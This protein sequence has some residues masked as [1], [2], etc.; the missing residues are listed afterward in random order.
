MKSYLA[1]FSLLLL[2]LGLV[3]CSGQGVTPSGLMPGGSQIAKL[4]LD[5][6]GGIASTTVTMGDAPPSLSGKQL[7]HLDLGIREIDVTDTQGRNKVVAQYDRPLMIDVLQ[8]QGGAGKDL[9]EAAIN[10]QTY[11]AIRFVVDVRVSHAIYA[12]SSIAPLAFAT[13]TDSE[14]T[15]GAGNTTTTS[16]DGPNRVAITVNQQFS[17]RPDVAEII[18][19][20]FNAFESLAPATGSGQN[21]DAGDSA[22][23]GGRLLVRPALF[24]AADWDAGRI[25]GTIVNREGGPVTGA[26][27]VAIGSGGDIGNTVATDSAGNFDLHA[28]PSGTYRLQIYNEYTNAAGASFGA[29]G[30]TSE[31][32][33]VAGPTLTVSPG[34]SL[35][36]G[37]VTD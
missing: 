29:Q 27:V 16:H 20:D 22:D 8:Y 25:T 4:P 33:V 32:E 1:P 13:D 6:H 28:L 35:S 17:I 24:V 5:T 10:G 18:R 31:R 34:G 37:T 3:A 26:T 9:G 2:A 21:G 14:S 19:A 23:T 12:D 30:A 11:R 36:I 15:A 7:A